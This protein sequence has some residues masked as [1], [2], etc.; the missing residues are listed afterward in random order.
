MRCHCSGRF[1]DFF[2]AQNRCPFL[3]MRPSM[4]DQTF[5]IIYVSAVGFVIMPA[6][7][8]TAN[9][10]LP[11]RCRT[12]TLRSC[13][14]KIGVIVH[15]LTVSSE[16][17]ESMIRG[18]VLRARVCCAEPCAPATPKHARAAILIAPASREAGPS[19][20]SRLEQPFRAYMHNH[21][22]VIQRKSRTDGTCISYMY[23]PAPL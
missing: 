21:S 20:G 23:P 16:L 14:H 7:V 22:S 18:F 11:Q 5:G 6:L 8:C 12:A 4:A 9:T 19:A 13:G 15:L 3:A 2:T 17:C 10:T 1:C